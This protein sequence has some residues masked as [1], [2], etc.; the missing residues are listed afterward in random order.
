MDA[1]RIAR[2]TCVDGSR[3]SSS[4]SGRPRAQVELRSERV[5]RPQPCGRAERSSPE[6]SGPTFV[7]A[8]PTPQK[9]SVLLQALLKEQEVL[10]A[11]RLG[12]WGERLAAGL[13]ARGACPPG[14]HRWRRSA[15]VAR[16]PRS[17]RCR[18]EE[19]A[20]KMAVGGEL[21]CSRWQPGASPAG[22][23][24][25]FRLDGRSQV[26]VRMMSHRSCGCRDF[27]LQ[28]ARR[29]DL[30]PVHGRMQQLSRA[31]ISP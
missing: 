7:L 17:S 5:L 13:G 2:K 25:C 4:D 26:V 20:R 3:V 15:A 30:P 8:L 18:P 11:R 9:C 27:L 22:L 16:A 23:S 10:V 14:W 31:L 21:T 29:H 24:K 1:S 19:V 6:D 12:R 28:E